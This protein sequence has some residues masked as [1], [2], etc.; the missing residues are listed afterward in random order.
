MGEIV[1][2]RRRSTQDLID[3]ANNQ[4]EPHL[5]DIDLAIQLVSETIKRSQKYTDEE[6]DQLLVTFTRSLQLSINGIK[7][8]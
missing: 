3:F 4:L 5:R 7:D 2:F 6:K 1:S 8:L